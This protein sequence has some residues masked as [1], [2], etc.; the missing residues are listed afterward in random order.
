MAW[1]PLAFPLF[2]QQHI[3]IF[4]DFDKTTKD[5]F[6]ANVIKMMSFFGERLWWRGESIHRIYDSTKKRKK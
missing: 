6:D 4:K 3:V 2:A 1:R 5:S